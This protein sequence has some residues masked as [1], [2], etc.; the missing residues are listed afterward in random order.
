MGAVRWRGRAVG[1]S[2]AEMI[3]TDGDEAAN[4]SRET[5]RRGGL[6]SRW[7]VGG[8]AGALLV[9]MPAVLLGGSP[10][11]QAAIASSLPVFPNNLV[12]FPNRDFIAIEGY[13]EY[14][15]LPALVEVTRPGVGIIGSATGTVSGTDVAFEVNHPGGYCWGAGGGLN[16]TPDILPGDVVSVKIAAANGLPEIH[17]ATTVLDVAANDAVQTGNTVTVTGRFGDGVDPANFEQ[18]IIEPA[19]RDFI[20]KRDVRAV[21]GVPGVLEPAPTGGYSSGAEIDV[22]QDKFTATYVFDDIAVAEIAANAGLGERAMAWEFVDAAANRQGLTIAENGEPGGPGFGGCPNGPLQSGP[23]APTNV[24]VSPFANSVEVHW[25]PAQALPG[26]PAILGYRVRAVQRNG[27]GSEQ[28]EFGKKIM[29]PSANSTTLS[30]FDP[31]QYDIEVMSINSVGETYPPVTVVPTSDTTAPVVT[32]SPAGGSYPIAQQ[33]TLTANEPGADIYYTLDS[34]NPLNGDMLNDGPQVLAYNGPITIAADTTLRF[35][36]FDPSN[37]VSAGVTE[38]YAITNDPVPA[39]TTITGA[40]VGLNQATLTWAAAAPGGPNLTIAGYEIDVFDSATATVPARTETSNGPG[41]STT[42]TGLVGDTPYWFTV[43]A[44]NNV[45]SVF[46]AD[47]PRFGPVT[48]QGATV[49]NAGSD[50]TNIM[51]GTVVNL[52][53]DGSTNTGATY[54]WQQLVGGTPVANGTGG[55]SIASPTSKN[56]SFTF[57]LYAYPADNVALTFRLSVTA[58]GVVRTDDVTI[59]PRSDTVT[60]TQAKWKA[61]DFRV[62]G[63]VTTP[64]ALVTVRRANGTVLGTATADALG[65]FSFRDRSNNVQTNP[66]TVFVD[67]NRGGTAGPVTVVN[68]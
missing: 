44:K 18:R 46:G 27:S 16:I 55:V 54:L 2:L 6:Q 1:A 48:P 9:G 60:V 20:G 57:P 50:Q 68:G 17:D 40:T 52:S 64:G 23:P 45:N 21:P 32:A 30:G 35:V 13:S 63:T 37:N 47:S 22:N 67:S 31:L 53:G 14:G 49:A 65:A 3:A 38:Q 58:N 34:S 43:R 41:V 15:G 29:N 12:V 61:R 5:R 28:L 7:I 56:T 42:I 4:G 19:L 66:G 33:V 10:T 51:R 36:A 39:A 25:T 8:L 26:T 62:V 59:S 11:S 24:A